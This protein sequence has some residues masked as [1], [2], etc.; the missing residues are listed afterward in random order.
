VEKQDHAKSY[1]AVNGG[2]KGSGNWDDWG[3]DRVGR[4]V[5]NGRGPVEKAVVGGW[6]RGWVIPENKRVHS[7]MKERETVLRGAL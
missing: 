3:G 4:N 2:R 6:T 5:W 7:Q 1:A